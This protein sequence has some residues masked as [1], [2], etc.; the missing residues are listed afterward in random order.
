M[1]DIGKNFKIIFQK[2]GIKLLVEMDIGE[3]I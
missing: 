2:L 1:Y 3:T